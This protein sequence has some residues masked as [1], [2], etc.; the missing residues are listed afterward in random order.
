[1]RL[2]QALFVEFEQVFYLLFE[3]VIPVSEDQRPEACRVAAVIGGMERA[4]KRS[5]SGWPSN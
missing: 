5:A 2:G 4:K 3:R 1:M